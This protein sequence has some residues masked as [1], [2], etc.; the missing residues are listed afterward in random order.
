MTRSTT[1]VLVGVLLAV[2][3]VAAACGG[4]EG[5]SGP[6]DSVGGEDALADLPECPVDALESATE[7]VEIT[8]WHNFIATGLPAFEEIV[9]A[10]NAS[11]DQVVVS[12]ESQ[13][14]A[15]EELQRKYN[16]AIQSGD[17]PNVALLED[18]QTLALADSGTLLPA[19]ACLE[20]SGETDDELVP[21]IIDYYSIDGVQYP[22]S[23]TPANA[24]L[25]FNRGHFEQ[26]GLDPDD[27]PGTLE[28]VRAAAQAI[29]DAGISEQPFALYLTPF[30]FEFWLTGAGI[31]FV[32]ND[33]GRGDG[34]TTEAVFDDERV[35]ELL[36]FF[37]DMQDDGL[38]EAF[39]YREGD[40]DHFFAMANPDE[41]QRGSM[42][43]ESSSAAA[44]IESFLK[45]E[46][47]PSELSEDARV[48]VTDDLELS[49]DVDAS[50]FPGIDAPGHVQVGGG[51]FY[52]MDT[53]TPEQQ[54][55]SWDFLQF[56]NQP[57]NQA[58]MSLQG[59]SD[60][61]NLETADLPEV[62]ETWST[63]LSGSWL[64]T[65]YDQMLE[66]I[67]P[68]FPGPLVG[69]YTEMR[70]AVVN[71]LDSVMVGDADP[72]T[73]L[74]EAEAEVTAAIERYQEQNF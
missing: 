28:E 10:Y 39:P 24:L 25:Y 7:P 57:E 61:V 3:L 71:L 17:L 32:D 18:T 46:L 31:P 67:D 30:L 60:P 15:F 42:L 73:A 74:A 47:D 21:T 49:L 12:A 9:A 23:A 20:A 34:E 54:A 72:A 62:Q 13:G 27:P 16:Q 52:M 5:G 22:A 2:A 59:G 33:N 19:S 41:S 37:V 56:F 43:V 66:G 64:Q 55:A 4:D 70:A 14:T 68:E 35:L 58:T 40:I 65:S 1:R 8:V 44:A 63:T 51:V 36:E 53:G 69:P 48:V 38:L 26:A 29:K 50:E 6:D 11:Q 45:G